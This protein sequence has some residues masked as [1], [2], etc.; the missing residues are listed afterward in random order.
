M[1][2]KPNRCLQS[3]L[4]QILLT[5]VFLSPIANGCYNI[6]MKKIGLIS[7]VHGNLEALHAILQVFAEEQVDEIIH[8][9]DV[10]NIGPKSS[11]C[12]DLLL[13]LPKVT[14]IMGNHDRDFALNQ[15][16]MRFMSHVPTEHKQQVFATMTE[17]QREIVASFPVFV[18]RSLAGKTV[19]FAHYAF[20]DGEIR[21]N[22]FLFKSIIEYPTAEK[23]DELFNNADCDA[24]FFGHKHEPCEIQGKKLYVDIGSV[25]CH[26]EPVARGIVID[27][28]DEKWSYRRVSASYDMDKMR[29]QLYETACGEQLYDYY[30]LKSKK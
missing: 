12:L 30:F 11:E 29:K 19:M 18:T 23:F 4:L 5:I 16:Q 17:R 3:S 28:D 21:P 7:D 22:K 2:Q 13:S 15:S 6:Y 20:N 8:T 14:L 25:G 1:L 27:C 24:I 9:G 26:S 10:V